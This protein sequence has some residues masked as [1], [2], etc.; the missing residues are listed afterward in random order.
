MI[1]ICASCKK[2]RTDDG[3]WNQIESYISSISNIEFTHSL[4]PECAKRI[5]PED[6]EEEK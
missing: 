6:E 4:C 5:F 1:P 3:Y 2:V